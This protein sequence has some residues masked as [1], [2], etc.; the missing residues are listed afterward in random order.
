MCPPF[1]FHCSKYCSIRFRSF[2]FSLTSICTCIVPTS[3]PVFLLF[4]ICMMKSIDLHQTHQRNATPCSHKH[5]TK[6]LPQLFCLLSQQCRL[7]QDPP[8]LFH[9]IFS[10]GFQGTSLTSCRRM[11]QTENPSGYP[12]ALLAGIVYPV[13]LASPLRVYLNQLAENNRLLR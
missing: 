8:T 2:F 13:P 10:Q 12:K 11:A 3:F 4:P 1:F 5:S 7:P 9:Y 6:K